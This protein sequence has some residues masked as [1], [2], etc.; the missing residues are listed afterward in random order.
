MPQNL[1][2]TTPKTTLLNRTSSGTPAGGILRISELISWLKTFKSESEIFI[3]YTVEDKVLGVNIGVSGALA[4]KPLNEESPAVAMPSFTVTDAQ[5]DIHGLPNS[6]LKGNTITSGETI[7]F[8]LNELSVSH[9]INSKFGMANV[10]SVRFL[11]GTNESNDTTNSS[12]QSELR[13][14]GYVSSVTVVEKTQ[15]GILSEVILLGVNP[16]NIP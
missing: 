12:L 2:I 11:N 15:D 1:S 5:P 8:L 4:F 3:H 14:L 9:Q 13:L 16:M 7:E 6:I 10:T